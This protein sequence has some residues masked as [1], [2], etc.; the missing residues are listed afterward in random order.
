MV[1]ILETVAESKGSE[2]Y[3]DG[4]ADEWIGSEYLPLL[5][6]LENFCAEAEVVRS[7]L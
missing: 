3:L 5:L 1:G 6:A 2:V 7:V 4:S